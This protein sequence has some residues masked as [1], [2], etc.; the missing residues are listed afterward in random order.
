VRNRPKALAEEYKQQQRG[1]SLSAPNVEAF[2][3]H[4]LR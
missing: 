1:D 4:R 2:K 3:S